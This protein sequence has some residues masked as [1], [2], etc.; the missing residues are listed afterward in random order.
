M[1]YGYGA[2]IGAQ[3]AFP[4]KKV[5]L[6]TGDGCFHMNLN[7]LCTSVKYNLPIVTV[8]FNNGVL[9]MVRQWQTQFYEKRYSSTTLERQTDFVMLAE[10]FGAKG[11]RVTTIQEFNSAIKDAF[12]SNRPCVIDAVIDKDEKVLPMI[13]AGKTIDEIIM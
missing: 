9:G 12:E 3:T 6:V 7:E 8:V 11:Y 13:P 10:A 2:S 1:G 5:A 4:N